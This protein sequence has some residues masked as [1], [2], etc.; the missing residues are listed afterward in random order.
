MKIKE[1]QQQGR[2]WGEKQEKDICAACA[3]LQAG[4]GVRSAFSG[5][6]AREG[7]WWSSQAPRRTD[8]PAWLRVRVRIR[9]RIRV[10][11]ASCCSCYCRCLRF[12][13]PTESNDS[14]FLKI[15]L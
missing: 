8:S 14:I 4:G 2:V 10:R 9:V 6:L 5:G 7:M 13:L 11:V 3:T 12:S 1:K 15:V